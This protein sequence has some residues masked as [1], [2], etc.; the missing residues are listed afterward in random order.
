[1]NMRTTIRLNEL[2]LKKA[3]IYAAKNST[4]LTKLIENSLKETLSRI[5]PGSKKAKVKLTTF[6]G[7][8]L[9]PGID[10]DDNASLLDSMES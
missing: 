3:K 9:M 4:S 8:G 10:L 1:M 2:L 6:K 7:D 5:S